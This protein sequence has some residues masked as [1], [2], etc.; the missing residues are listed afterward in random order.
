MHVIMA[1]N[2]ENLVLHPNEILQK[3]LF[4]DINLKFGTHG[5]FCPLR[6]RV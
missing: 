6:T 3:A 1:S 4:L 5:H 2:G